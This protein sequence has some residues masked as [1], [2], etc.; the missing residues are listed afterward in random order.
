MHSTP[1]VHVVVAAIVIVVLLLIGVAAASTYIISPAD[2]S[3]SSSSSTATTSQLLSSTTEVSSSTT[4]STAT[5]HTSSTTI[6]ST[7]TSSSSSLIGPLGITVSAAISDP[8]EAHAGNSLYIYSVA[9]RD[10][11]NVPINV[12]SSK[13]D[14]ITASK[15]VYDTTLINATQQDL[16]PIALNPGESTSGQIAFQ[17]PSSQTPSELEYNISDSIHEMVTHLPSPSQN[18]SELTAH[19]E[20]IVGG[21]TKT[22]GLEDLTSNAAIQNGSLFFYSG[23][24][25]AIKVA[26]YNSSPG[27]TVS[28]VSITTTTPGIKIMGI[29]PALPVAVANTANGNETVVMVYA[30]A[31]ATSFSGTIALNISG[32]D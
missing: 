28:V 14:L 5:S 4:T 3:S 21:V 12:N 1:G 2:P 9:L 7:T 20:T 8:P 13:F 27:T 6:T 30:A 16:G 26:L 25:I 11:T 22:Y 17:F 10:N 19:V 31:P 29:S 18:V 15:N 24:T 32:T 23:Q